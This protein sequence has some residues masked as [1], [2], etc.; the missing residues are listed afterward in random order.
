MSYFVPSIF[1]N[2]GGDGLTG[3]WT[4]CMISDVLGAVLAAILLFTQREIF[5]MSAEQIR[6][7]EESS[8]ESAAVR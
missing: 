5:K 7:N 8:A 4:S 2:L 6:V 1:V 3:V